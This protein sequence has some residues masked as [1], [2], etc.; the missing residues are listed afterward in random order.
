MEKCPKGGHCNV[1][2]LGNNIYNFLA[3]NVVK[4]LVVDQIKI[5]GSFVWHLVVI[6]FHEFVIYVFAPFI[7]CELFIYVVHL[8]IYLI[9]CK[10]FALYHICKYHVPNG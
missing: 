9:Y 7:I 5:R 1:L 8:T 2:S 4:K 3:K 10:V 6:K